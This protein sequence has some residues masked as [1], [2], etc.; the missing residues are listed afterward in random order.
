MHALKLHCFYFQGDCLF[1]F[2]FLESLIQNVE[3][4]TRHGLLSILFTEVKGTAVCLVCGV[5]HAEKYKNLTDA[6]RAWTSEAL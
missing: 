2:F 4:F 3:F 5:Q 6:E 1:F